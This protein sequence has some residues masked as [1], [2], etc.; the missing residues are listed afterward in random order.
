MVPA[1]PLTRTVVLAVA[2]AIAGACSRTPEPAPRPAQGER[3]ARAAFE[4]HQAQ[5]RAERRE[6]LLA[7][8][9]WTTLMGLH[10]LSAGPHY[11]G[12]AHD[13]GVRTAVGPAQ[14]G[15]IDV[16]P[17]GIRL[18]ANPRAGL[19]VDGRALRGGVDLRTDENGAEPTR[20]GFDDGR[21]VATVIKRGDRYAL[22][23]RHVDAPTRTGFAGLAYWA[24]GPGWVVDARFV[25]HRPARTLPITNIVGT[26]DSTPN[27]GAV[28]FE[29]EGRQFRLEALDDGKGGL[30]L[31]F[32]DRTSGHGSYGAGRYL[33]AR[34]PDARGGVR[35]D[36]NRA[37][38][39]PCA[40]TSFATCP[41]PPPENRLDL[42]IDAG[43]KAYAGRH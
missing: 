18:V 9:G 41:L 13:N 17:A 35:L 14:L 40:F 4:R 36:F 34:A 19:A 3:D 16:R 26:V 32:A 39:P 8:D 42:R 30:F 20:I 7:P 10:W 2:F 15:M 25:P 33:D 37:Y 22:R 38:N 31:I 43:E 21:G 6:A 28:V 11:V 27:P 29:R 1:R 24:G 23:M 5:W 12:T